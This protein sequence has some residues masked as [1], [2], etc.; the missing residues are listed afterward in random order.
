MLVYKS[1]VDDWENIERVGWAT[2]QIV[3]THD[4]RVRC[5]RF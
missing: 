2:I 1:Q 4:V 5:V 3:E